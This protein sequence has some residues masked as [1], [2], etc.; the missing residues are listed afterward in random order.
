MAAIGKSSL[1]I[2][3]SPAKCKK[4]AGFLGP[5][6]QILA[7]MGH[8]RALEEDLDAVGLDRD[9]EPRFRFLAEKSKATKLIL[10]AAKYA[11]VIYLAA[12]DDREGE[13]IAYSVA[14]S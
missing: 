3:E 10:D 9:F 13:A 1:V 5:G 12:D 8:I 7:T 4:I 14:V 2:V 6:F 11:D